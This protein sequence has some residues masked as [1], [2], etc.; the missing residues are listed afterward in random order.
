MFKVFLCLSQQQLP[1]SEPST[2]KVPGSES[3]A[4]RDFFFT[5]GMEL[6][7]IIDRF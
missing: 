5:L 7:E 1:I 6:V 2:K 3:L 4:A